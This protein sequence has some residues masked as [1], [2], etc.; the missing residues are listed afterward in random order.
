MTEDNKDLMS[1]LLCCNHS[2]ILRILRSLA[3]LRAL[4]NAQYAS[5][6][7]LATEHVFFIIL[8]VCGL[9]RV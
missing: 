3:Q 5:K 7:I 9:K 1:F 4:E 6:K 8:F 2:K